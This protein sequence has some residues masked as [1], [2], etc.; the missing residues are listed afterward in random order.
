M[1]QDFKDIVDAG[2]FCLAVLPVYLIVRNIMLWRAK[3]LR[4]SYRGRG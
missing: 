2:I 3:R 4:E 1:S